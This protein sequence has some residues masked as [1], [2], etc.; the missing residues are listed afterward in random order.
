ELAQALL[1]AEGIAN[2]KD[3]QLA[4]SELP[5]VVAGPWGS[6]S[7]RLGDDCAAIPDGEGYLLL[8]AEGMLP[9][10]VEQE[11]RAAGYCAVLVNASDVYAMGGRPLAVVDA[12]FS[13]GATTAARILEGMR[14]AGAD[15]GIPVVGGHTNLKSPYAALA[16]AIVGRAKALLISFDARP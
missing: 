14:R 16:V 15:L 8:A 6:T 9:E 4:G 12:L 5:W 1:K 11:P 3:I 10:F 2:K 13:H 7:V